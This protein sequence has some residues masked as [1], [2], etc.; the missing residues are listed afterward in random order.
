MDLSGKNQSA[1]GDKRYSVDV[2]TA[3]GKPCYKCC[4][5][6]A[7]AQWWVWSILSS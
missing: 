4:N 3:E 2:A 7:G 6:I 1:V 5:A